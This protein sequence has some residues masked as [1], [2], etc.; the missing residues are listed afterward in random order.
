MKTNDL[1]KEM[2]EYG[3]KLNE[4]NQALFDEIM[5]KIRFSKLQE[6]DAEE[7]NHHCLSLFIQA[8]K[9]G[10]DIKTVLGTDNIDE[11]C[12]EYIR[13]V[14]GN[15]SLL[16]KIVLASTIIPLVMAI[17]T[18]VWEMLFGYLIPLWV[19]DRTISFDVPITL[20]MI[21]DTIIAF[22]IIKLAIKT[23][24]KASW[25]LNH[26]SKKE[27]RKWTFIMFIVAFCTI[28]I[29]VVTK[30]LFNQ[31]LFNLNF[32]IYIIG[33]GIFYL[34]LKILEKRLD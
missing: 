31:M 10:K 28:G 12:N 26:G 33:I 29:F 11:F 20:S 27:D 4:E 5:L 1:I 14:R 17:F 34:L 19:K 25:I 23:L 24:P 18:G 13:E 6:Q 9:E 2:N 32:I 16:K 21:I 3:P 22:L 30:L 8:E 15:Y 7:F